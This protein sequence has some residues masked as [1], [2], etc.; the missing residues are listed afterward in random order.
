MFNFALEG[1]SFINAFNRGNARKLAGQLPHPTDK[2]DEQP[3]RLVAVSQGHRRGR[4]TL[5]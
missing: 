5:S 2:L 4:H 1:T 3:A